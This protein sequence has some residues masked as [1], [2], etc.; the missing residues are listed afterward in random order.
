[1][2]AEAN[3]NYPALFIKKR[4][5]TV[6]PNGKKIKYRLKQDSPFHHEMINYFRDRIIEDFS[7]ANAGLYTWIMRGTENNNTIYASETRSK[8]EIGTLHKNLVDLTQYKDKRPLF[9]AG[10]LEID[11]NGAIRFNLQSG[12]FND[13][14]LKSYKTIKSKGDFIMKTVV[15]TVISTLNRNGVSHVTFLL[16]EK[17]CDETE[18]TGGKHLLSNAPLISKE[19]NIAIYNKYFNRL[20][21]MASSGGFKQSGTKRNKP[22]R[23]RTKQQKTKTRKHRR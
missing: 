20:N 19:E 7:K 3:R 22:K 1:M 18:I 9:A 11:N 10:E 17:N 5:N 2:A 15:P 13:T 14:V 8:Q 4:E 16:C 6:A 21:N 23:R 12:L